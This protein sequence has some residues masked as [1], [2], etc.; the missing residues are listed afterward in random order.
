MPGCQV[1]SVAFFFPNEHTCAGSNLFT[2]LLMQVCNLL[3]KW[4]AEYRESRLRLGE[5][6]ESLLRGCPKPT[7]SLPVHDTSLQPYSWADQPDQLFPIQRHQTMPFRLIHKVRMEII[8]ITYIYLSLA[9]RFYCSLMK[10]VWSAS[11]LLIGRFPFWFSVTHNTARKQLTGVIKTP[12]WNH[13]CLF[14]VLACT[15]LISTSSSR[16]QASNL[17]FRAC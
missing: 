1:I 17:K 6:T 13:F 11:H 4:A 14:C 9:L 10:L 2:Q 5:E 8:L 7:H 3:Q 16:K 12:H 15:L